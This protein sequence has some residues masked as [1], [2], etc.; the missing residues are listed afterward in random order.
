MYYRVTSLG[1]DVLGF[2]WPQPQRK[3]R[4][5]T[6]GWWNV[7]CADVFPAKLLL[8]SSYPFGPQWLLPVGIPCPSWPSWRF[9]QSSGH[10]FKCGFLISTETPVRQEGVQAWILYVIVIYQFLGMNTSTGV[11][12]S[13]KAF[14]RKSPATQWETLVTALLL[15]CM[16]LT[17]KWHI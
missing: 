11:T 12:W 5:E 16:L 7:P 14:L 4:K 1:A 17:R 3:F 15:L 8:T 9:G 6:S 13:K 2:A 10:S